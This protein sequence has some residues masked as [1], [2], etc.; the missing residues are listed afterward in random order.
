MK[1]S[2]S[3][4]LIILEKGINFQYKMNKEN[5]KLGCNQSDTRGI[6]ISNSEPREGQKA[7]EHWT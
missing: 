2:K 4:S 1:H 3:K 5:L 6:L 7:G